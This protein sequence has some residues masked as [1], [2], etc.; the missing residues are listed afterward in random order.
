MPPRISLP[1]AASVEDLTHAVGVDRTYVGRMLRLTS[2][3]RHIS[4]AALCGDEPE[5][6]SLGRLRRPLPVGW[7]EHKKNWADEANDQ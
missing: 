5:G 6:M 3:A 2:L 7:Q 1:S 4:G